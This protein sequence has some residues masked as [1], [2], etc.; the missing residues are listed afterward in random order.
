MLHNHLTTEDLGG[1]THLNK[2]SEWEERGGG[3][4]DAGVILV[5]TV[6]P[7]GIYTGIQCEQ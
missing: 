6:R 2:N 3:L 7:S 4:A 1:Y 5:Y